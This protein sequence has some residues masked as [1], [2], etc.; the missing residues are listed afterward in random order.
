LAEIILVGFWWEFIL[1]GFLGRS[2]FSRIF[3]G[4]LFWHDFGAEVS[5]VRF[6]VGIYFGMIFWRKLF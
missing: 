6:L 3:C 5:L 4:N 2:Y 1:T